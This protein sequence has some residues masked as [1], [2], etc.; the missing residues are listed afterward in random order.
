MRI[1]ENQRSSPRGENKIRNEAV[2]PRTIRLKSSELRG[3]ILRKALDLGREI[4]FDALTMERISDHSGIAKTTIYRRWPNVSALIMDAVLSDISQWAPIE[5]KTT[6][7]ETFSAA[8]KLLIRLYTGEHGKTVR[9]LIGRAQTDEDLRHAVT[10]QWVE[11][12]RKL[13]REILQR[14]MERGE[15]RSNINPD[16]VLDAL[17]GAIYHRFLVPPQQADMSDS[18]VD[19]V[20]AAVFLG[21]VAQ[22]QQG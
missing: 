14:G 19:E 21:I 8:M 11:P 12:R 2:A 22:G 1:V 3:S 13:A 10:I 15:I 9:T 6:I 4:G 20:I 17:Y 16:I 18:F 7:R 5:E